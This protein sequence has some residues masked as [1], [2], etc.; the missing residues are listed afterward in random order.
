MTFYEIFQMAN[1]NSSIIVIIAIAVLSLLEI[2]KVKFNP[3]S[4]LGSIIHKDIVKEL[5]A[6]KLEISELKKDFNEFKR[7][8]LFNEAT[9]ARRRILRFND[10][11][12]FGMKHTIEHF[13]EIIEDIDNY[14]AFCRENPDYQNNKGKMAMQNIKSIYQK[15][16]TDNTFT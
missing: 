15:C 6:N 7:E 5:E 4:W 11:A 8:Q 1:D 14:E 9:A 16:I 13:D 3:W 10:E 2:S 12:V